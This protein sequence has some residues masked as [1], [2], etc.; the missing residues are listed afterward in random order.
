MTYIPNLL[1]DLNSIPKITKQ[2]TRACLLVALKIQDG[3]IANWLNLKPTRVSNIKAELNEELFS[4]ASARSLYNN[5]RQK[6]NI[7]SSGKY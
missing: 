7:I 6:Y 1:S 4:D 5:L 2:K 3:C